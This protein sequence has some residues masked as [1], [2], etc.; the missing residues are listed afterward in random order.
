MRKLWAVMKFVGR[1]LG[2]ALIMLAAGL[3]LFPPM[4]F[5]DIASTFALPG[6]V[7][8]AIAWLLTRGPQR[9]RSRT[10]LA[11]F[12][13]AAFAFTAW[14]HWEERRGYHTETVS[15]ASRGARL[16]GTLY[17]PDRPGT[18]P[19]IVWV[20]GSGTLARFG[21]APFAQ[22]FARLGYAVLVYDKRGV[23]DS[24]G[25]FQGG[26]SAIC[27]NNVELLASDAAAALALL[28][29]RPEVRADAAGFV[30]ASQAGWLVP[31]AAVLNGHA[32]FMLLLSGP[33]TST[34]AFLRYE[35]FRLGPPSGE[36]VNPT[37]AQVFK[38]YGRGDAPPGL[39]PDQVHALA[40]KTAQTFP[41]GDYDPVTDLRALDVP[42][43]WLLGGSEWIVPPGPTARNLEALQA[44]GK[45]YRYRVIPGADH[46]MI[47][48][49][50]RPVLDAVDGWLAQVTM[51]RR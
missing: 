51:A 23:G 28:A 38:A 6:A 14:R 24:T 35:R 39:T 16:V 26:E 46:A 1:W 15:F 36:V 11:A 37:A 22:H 41:C 49:P 3:F 27:P 25:R 34:H 18:V 33:V 8:T 2:P 32:A 9:R 31:R 29:R 42:G 19:G 4:P 10:V 48:G 13:L 12:A 30:G 43:L 40:Q 17:L 45:P 7:I 50:R 5:V 20:H 44:L 47:F 21:Y